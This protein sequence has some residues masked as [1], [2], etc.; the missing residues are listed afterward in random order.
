MTQRGNHARR[1][2]VA[3]YSGA[4]IVSFS[5][6]ADAALTL[7]LFRSHIVYEIPRLAVEYLAERLKRRETYASYFACLDARQVD[8]RNANPLGKLYRRNPLLNH[9]VIKAHN[10]RHYTTCPILNATWVL[11]THFW[12]NNRRQAPLAYC[13]SLIYR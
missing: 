1:H 6:P 5:Y 11:N 2:I 10:Y 7:R 8:R 12:Y 4:L 9:N 3:P 13:L